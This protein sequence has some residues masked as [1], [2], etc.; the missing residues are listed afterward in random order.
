MGEILLIL[1]MAATALVLIIGIATMIRGGEFNQKYG[2][3]MMVLR[4][5]FQGGTLLLLGILFL[6][7]NA[8]K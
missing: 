4:V 7:S 8:S 1:M 6:I 3:K 2:N 5:A